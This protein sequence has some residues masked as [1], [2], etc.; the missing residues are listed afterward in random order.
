MGPAAV[1]SIAERLLTLVLVA[2]VAVWMDFDLWLACAAIALGPMA[3]LLILMISLHQ[4][5]YAVRFSRPS[6]PVLT[7]W[8][9][10]AS[11]GITALATQAQKL[12]VIIVGALAGPVA[13]GIFAVPARL[14][15]PLGLL[16][17][18][19]S[20]ALFPQ[21]SREQIDTSGLQEGRA[22]AA[23]MALVSGSLMLVY[24][25]ADPI[26]T[27]TLGDQYRA[28][29]E[30][31]R[32]YLVGMGLASLNQPLAVILQARHDERYVARATTFGAIAGL[33]F[34]ALGAW[35]GDATGAASGFVALQIVNLIGL[36]GRYLTIHLGNEAKI[37][38]ELVV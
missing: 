35:A 7:Q 11:F 29:V 36:G 20:A 22:L 16:P 21:M 15:G 37:H 1:A 30:V 17:S 34:V 33:V 27:L 10:S 9:K 32:I 12:D 8:R 23:M 24:I 5:Q 25:F 18:A 13:A 38:K 19:F 3:P 26:V 28:S 6:L 2:G 4:T 31:L 14:T